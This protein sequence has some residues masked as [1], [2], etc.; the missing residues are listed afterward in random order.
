MRIIIYTGKGGVGKTSVAAAAALRAA[1][2][3]YRTLIMSTDAAHSLSDS[4]DRELGHDP[5][6]VAPNLW[7]IQANAYADLEANWGVVRTHI[8]RLV[9]LQGMDEVLADEAAILPG[10]DELF[11]LGRI[12]ELSESGLYDCIIVDAAPTGETLRLLSLPQTLAWSVKMLRKADH[13]IIRPI[14]RPLARLSP[15]IEEMIAPEEVFVAL[16]S[17]LVKLRSIKKLLADTSR[18]TIRLVMNPEKMVINESKRALTYLNMYGL[19]VDSIVVNRMLAPNSGYLEGWR[20]LQERYLAEVR[21]S[22]APIPIQIAP[23]YATE[24]IGN[25]GLSRLAADLYGKS[26]PT[27]I[28]FRDCIFEIKKQKGEYRLRIRLPMLQREKLRIRSTGDELVLQLENQRRIISLPSALSG[29]R[30]IRA[31]YEESYL[32]V[33]FGKDKEVTEEEFLDQ[34]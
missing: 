11:S 2:F 28:M 25:E 5:L 8:A 21:L 9:A 22:F 1:S 30:P 7:A 32:V 26:D 16:E 15:A 31:N 12:K 14:I 18:T 27:E 10:M 19:L 17:M 29:Y 13:Y 6:E 34:N 24:V 4:Y 33:C 3:G 20:A 23:Q